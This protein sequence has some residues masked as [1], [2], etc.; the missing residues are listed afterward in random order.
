MVAGEGNDGIAG[1]S[2]SP[3]PLLAPIIG[4]RFK[5]APFIARIAAAIPSRPLPCPA[6]SLAIPRQSISFGFPPFLF[7]NLSASRGDK[8]VA[9]LPPSLAPAFPG[10]SSSFFFLGFCRCCGFLPF[11]IPPRHSCGGSLLCSHTCP[12]LPASAAERRQCRP[13]SWPPGRA[14]SGSATTTTTTGSS[15]GRRLSLSLLLEFGNNGS[16]PYVVYR[17]DRGWA[18]ACRTG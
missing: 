18:G 2:S 11:S 3:C 9:S 14:G 16:S 17:L 6:P 13:T 15:R 5:C 7:L 12:S 8:I 4:E 10:C 1:W